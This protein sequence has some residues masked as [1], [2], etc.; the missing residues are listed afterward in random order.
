[1]ENKLD[2]DQEVIID[3]ENR[4]KEWRDEDYDYYKCFEY[5]TICFIVAIFAGVVIFVFIKTALLN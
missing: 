2:D 1:M 5:T 4:E 3:I